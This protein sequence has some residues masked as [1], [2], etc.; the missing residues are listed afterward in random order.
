MAVKEIKIKKEKDEDSHFLTPRK[1]E[2]QIEQTVVKCK[3]TRLEA[4][5]IWCKENEYDPE[6]VVPLINTTLKQNLQIDGIEN[7]LLKRK[8]SLF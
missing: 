6:D 4:I 5:F 8:N 1:F 7:G 3:C 2:E